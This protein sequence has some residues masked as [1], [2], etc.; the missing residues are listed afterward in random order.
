MFSAPDS[1]TSDIPIQALEAS[2]PRGIAQSRIDVKE[3]LSGE[4][5]DGDDDDED[6]KDGDTASVLP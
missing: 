3:E 2:T 5:D 1:T 6:N 4:D